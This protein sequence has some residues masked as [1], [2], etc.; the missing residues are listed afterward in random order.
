MKSDLEPDMASPPIEQKNVLA[1][2][3][4]AGLFRMSPRSS[5]SFKS[6]SFASQMW[7]FPANRPAIGGMIATPIKGN[8]N[9]FLTDA[10]CI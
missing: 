9:T 5:V 1:G 8:N 3:L 6:Q 7:A 2:L 4:G 10:D